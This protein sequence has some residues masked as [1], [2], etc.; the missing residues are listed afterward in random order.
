MDSSNP[1]FFHHSD[2]PGHML[3]P[4][5]LNGANYSSWSQSMIHALIAKNKLGFVDG[6]IQRP[7]E[8][9]QPKEYA[10]WNQCNSMVLTWLSHSVEPGLTKGV[11]HAKIAH[12]VWK[13]FK[14]Q[15]SQKN[16][17][18]VYQIQKSIASLS[19]GTMTVQVYFSKLKDLWDELEAYRPPLT[20]NEEKTHRERKEEDQMMQFLMGLSDTFNNVRTN[21]LMM[22]PL[23]NIRQAYSLVIQDETQRQITSSTTENFS[24]AAAIQS[25]QNNFSNDSKQ[26]EV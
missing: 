6:S 22:T 17:P 20:C 9:E 25:R 16:A 24:L 3:V 12:Q 10:L 4:E 18:T 8:K 11:I 1:Y 23:P 15:F 13:D 26:K 5:K 21:I 14:D 19:Q 7:S 2:H